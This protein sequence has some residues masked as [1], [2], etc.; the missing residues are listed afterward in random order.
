MESGVTLSFETDCAAVVGELRSAL[1]DLY[2]AIGMDP[3]VPQEM[4]R[5]FSLNKTLTWHLSRLIGED[6]C[7]PAM[8]HIPGSL[9]MEKVLKAAKGAGATA[10]QC[11]RVRGAVRRYDLV[12]RRHVDDRTT[13]DLMLDGMATEPDKALEASRRLAYRGASG[14]RGV[15]VQTRVL[16]AFLIPNRDD[17]DRID[18]AAV[19]GYIGVRRL[20]PKVRCMLLSVRGWQEQ[21]DQAIGWE[22]IFEPLDGN[23][24]NSILEHYGER[25]HAGKGADLVPT[26]DGLEIMLQPGQVGNQSIFDIARAD[27]LRGLGNRWA[28]GEDSTGEVSVSLSVPSERLVF[29]LLYHRDLSFVRNARPLLFDMVDRASSGFRSEDHP[30]LLPLTPAL[31][32]LGPGPIVM[33]TPHV[34]GHGMLARKV[35]ERLG[36]AFEQMRGIRMEL[37]YPPINSEITLRFNLPQKA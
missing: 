27:V 8:Q 19:S 3:A 23:P 2:A 15:Q 25:G 13:L 30:G 11:D 22:P 24:S 14:I 5:R 21:D 16:N 12:V 29:D 36:V 7:L 37:D 18:I 28:D 4:A 31:T 6:R 35:C 1:E 20:R 32:D 26:D 33:S 34:P 9:A 17:P 10:D